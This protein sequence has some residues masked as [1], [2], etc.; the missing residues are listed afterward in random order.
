MLLDVLMLR[1]WLFMGE[2]EMVEVFFVCRLR[3]I[4]YKFEMYLVEVLDFRYWRSRGREFILLL[5]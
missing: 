4:V 1:C 5:I 2:G 3:G